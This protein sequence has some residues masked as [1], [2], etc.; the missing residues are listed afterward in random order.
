LKDIYDFCTSQKTDKSFKNEYHSIDNDKLKIH[1]LQQSVRYYVSNKGG[2]LYKRHRE[3]GRLINYCVGY[4]VTLF[5]DY[6]D[7]EDYDINYNYYIKETQK[8][9]DQVINP[10]LKLF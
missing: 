3:D 9:I 10:Q 4:N 6:V 2:S 5:N 1:E 8:I 7:K